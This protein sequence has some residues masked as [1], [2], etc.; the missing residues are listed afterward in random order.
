MQIKKRFYAAFLVVLLTASS[1]LIFICLNILSSNQNNPLVPVP[2]DA[3]WVL[4]LDAESFVKKE[5]YNT[6]F[7]DKDDAFILKVRELIDKNFD[8]E[9][10]KKSLHIDPREDIV[11]Y[12]IDR[13]NKS[14]LLIAVQTKELT[15]SKWFSYA[16][17]YY[18]S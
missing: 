2:D 16:R 13:N 9:S 6:L 18:A 4:R 8:G 14:Y 5:V 7:A 15:C 17:I 1:L 10:N 12:S 11:L 3:N